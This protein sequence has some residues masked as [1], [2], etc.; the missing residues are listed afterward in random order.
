LRPQNFK[1]LVCV[2]DRASETERSRREHNPVTR[3]SASMFRYQRPAKIIPA[4]IIPAKIIPAKIITVDQYIY[5]SKRFLDTFEI[6]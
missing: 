6:V 5:M 2:W 3:S 1:T 4:K